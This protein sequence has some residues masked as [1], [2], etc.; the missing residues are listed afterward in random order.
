MVDDLGIVWVC[1]L[2]KGEVKEWEPSVER[3]GFRYHGRCYFDSLR[4]PKF[5]E[6][7]LQVAGRGARE[8]EI[9]R[10]ALVERGVPPYTTLHFLR[11]LVACGALE[12][13][14]DE[15]KARSG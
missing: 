3:G 14:G 9:V 7:L 2:C 13:A 4:R 6:Y 15:Y 12:R 1:P 10:R 8:G 5:T 11:Q